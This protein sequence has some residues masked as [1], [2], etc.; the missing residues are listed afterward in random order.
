[1]VPL[2]LVFVVDG[3]R[4]LKQTWPVAVMAGIVFAMTQFVI[5]N[6]FAIELTDV[7][8][9]IVTVG[10]VL[11]MLRFWQ[12]TENI[13]SS[14]HDDDAT[15]ALEPVGAASTSAADVPAADRFSAKT[16][17]TEAFARAATSG[18]HHRGD[19][20]EPDTARPS[21][22]HILMATAPYLI[23]IVIFSLAQIPAIKAWLT[24]VGSV[25]FH[26]PGLDVT[27][28]AGK[29]VAAQMFK[30]DHLK[31]TGT[32]LLLSGLLTMALYKVKP[33]KG[34]AIYKEGV[35]QLR[36]TIV[37]VS[38][39]LALSFVMSLSGQTT[40][41]GVALASAGGFFAVLSPVIGWVGVALTGSDTSS[42]S[43]FGQLQVT[44]ATQTGLSP[45]LMAV[46][47]S[48]AGALGKM[49]SVQN[50]AV[51]AAAAG[52][53]GGEGTLFRKLLGWSLGLL[54][55]MAGLVLL[56][57]TPVLAWMVP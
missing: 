3:R 16:S 49:V 4:G 41:M 24:S 48:S 13:T 20:P 57:S 15:L 18:A 37:T 55:L 7:I 29:P 1:V 23:I 45:V 52:L 25:T 21:G 46:S 42:N 47:N 8:A 44:A 33:A 17:V 40:T 11:V 51:A 12:P 54:V 36:W 22:R 2:V 38:T 56:Q 43:L 39:V 27:D 35:Y 6:F 9:A 14:A 30:L 53:E 32:L 28:S 19:T 5:S 10:A 31:A 50:L 26:W 34:W